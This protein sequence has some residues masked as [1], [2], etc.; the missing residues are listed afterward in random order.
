M[1]MGAPKGAFISVACAALEG[2]SMLRA[3][4]AS[5]RRRSYTAHFCL[6]GMEPVP[7]DMW[8][9]QAAHQGGRLGLQDKAVALRDALHGGVEGSALAAGAPQCSAQGAPPQR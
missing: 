4:G 7:P 2:A 3:V 6:S 5:S 9:I 8:G 1:K